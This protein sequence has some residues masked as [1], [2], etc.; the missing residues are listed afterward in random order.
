MALYNN[1]FDA[2][3]IALGGNTVTDTPTKAVDITTHLGLS[4]GF[5]V[6]EGW[7]GPA[8]VEFWAYPALAGSNG[9]QPDLANGHLIQEGALC[10]ITGATIE[11]DAIDFPTTLSPGDYV[12]G[13]PRCP[14][15]KF[16]SVKGVSGDYAHL[17]PVVVQDR[18]T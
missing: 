14:D 16:I 4:I 5:E 13:R 15:E 18:Q 17:S 8:R 12:W 1:G 10:D 2:R 6:L 7:T 9:C 11:G 3:G